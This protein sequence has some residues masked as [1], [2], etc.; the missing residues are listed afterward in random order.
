MFL[1]VLASPQKAS[2][3][4]IYMGQA[5]Y[6]CKELAVSRNIYT[7]C[8]VCIYICTYGRYSTLRSIQYILYIYM[9]MIYSILMKR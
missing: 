6:A 3:V 7:M 9:S 2:A 8:H 1:A 4:N 5:R